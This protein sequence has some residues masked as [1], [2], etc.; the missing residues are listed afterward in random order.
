M[1]RA[2][3]LKVGAQKSSDIIRESEYTKRDN[4]SNKYNLKKV[5]ALSP[6]QES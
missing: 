6:S 3:P 2:K 1:E 4:K 5:K